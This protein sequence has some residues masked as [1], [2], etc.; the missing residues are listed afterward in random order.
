[1]NQAEY[2][3]VQHALEI[4][5]AM[6]INLDLRGFLNK[7]SQTQALAPMIDP[8]LYRVA[9]GRLRM[10]QELAQSAKD[11]Q[12]VARKVAKELEGENGVE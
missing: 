3:Q 8:T 5:A 2:E 11:Y 12:R 4:T 7:I 9:S 1:M 6:I 10:I